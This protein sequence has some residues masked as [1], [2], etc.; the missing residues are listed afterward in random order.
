MTSG[1]VALPPAGCKPDREQSRAAGWTVFWPSKP[2]RRGHLAWR[3]TANNT[4]SECLREKREGIEQVDI[5]S[6]QKAIAAGEKWYWSDVPCLRG[7][8]GWRSAIGNR[9]CR[10][11]RSERHKLKRLANAKPRRVYTIE[12]H[13]AKAREWRA[14]NKDQR[15]LHERRRRARKRQAEG[16][17][18]LEDVIDILRLQKGRCAYCRRK[19]QGVEQHVDHI[20]PLSKGGSDAR[21]NIQVLCESCNCRKHATDPIEWARKRGALL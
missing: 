21:R 16:S 3:G 11:C 8:V 17:H 14:A 4:C 18:T 13:R 5:H 12:D 1:K 6:R 15:A 2:C 10:Q 7:H 19:L 20:V 9:C